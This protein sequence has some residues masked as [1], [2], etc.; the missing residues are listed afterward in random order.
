MAMAAHQAGD[1][2]MSERLSVL[3]VAAGRLAQ[4]AGARLIRWGSRHD[5]ADPFLTGDARRINRARLE[6]LAS[7]GL[8]LDGRRVLEVGAGIGLLTS[9]FE[10]RGCEVLSTDGRP[11]HVAEMR[12]RWPRRR[13]ERVDLD[14]ISARAALA[15]LGP[16]DVVFCYGTL[17]H[18][19]D[20]DG[21]LAALAGVSPVILL[22][23]CVT[24]GRHVD[25]HP[26]RESAAA[27]QA[28]GAVGCRPTRPWVMEQLVRHWG[29]AY[30]SR[31]QPR[32]EEF[33]TD[34]QVPAKSG[35]HRA[36]FVGS[37]SPLGLE[38]LLSELPVRQARL[39][40]PA[41]PTAPPEAAA[42]ASS[43][44]HPWQA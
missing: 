7:L 19:A 23:T 4:R 13:V 17:Y 22:E 42:A 31:R 21:A 36:V 10:A 12:R 32:H 9:F 5:A 39:G 41:E 29:F 3:A 18:L 2:V 14:A 15:A 28:L 38:T 40:D 27:N 11:A 33:E 30:V 37:K 43:Q 25:V 44:E 16:F 24:P 35:N 1:P 8:D 6:H 34:W 26:V 20:P